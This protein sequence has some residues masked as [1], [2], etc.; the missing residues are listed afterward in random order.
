MVDV[1][2]KY[3]VQGRNRVHQ[4]G[5]KKAE[6]KGRARVTLVA[7]HDQ[8]GTRVN[9]P[10]DY[11]PKPQ[12]TPVDC[13]RQICCGQYKC[14]GNDAQD[15]DSVEDSYFASDGG[16]LEPGTGEIRHERAGKNER[17]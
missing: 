16:C 3:C 4:C 12:F 8:K 15:S 6:S 5:L 1:E 13:G 9:D 10:R 14:E 17:L 2:E 11:V 7:N